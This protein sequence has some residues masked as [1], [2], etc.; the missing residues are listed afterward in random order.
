[1]SYKVY[2]LISIIENVYIRTETKWN[3][4]IENDILFIGYLG[5]MDYT[6]G[7]FTSQEGI[8]AMTMQYLRLGR[9]GGEDA[10]IKMPNRTD[11]NHSGTVGEWSKMKAKMDPSAESSGCTVEIIGVGIGFPA[12][13]PATN[14]G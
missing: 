14:K 13:R 7:P 1:M 5:L 10:G 3:Q 2:I 9:L 11:N 4:E 8:P 12:Q 6:H